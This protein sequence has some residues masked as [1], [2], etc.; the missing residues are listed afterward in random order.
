[1]EYIYYMEKKMEAMMEVL[2]QELEGAFEV[3]DKKSLHRYVLLLTE[4]IVKKE[5]YEKQQLELRNDIQT[6]AENQ[7]QGFEIMNQ[8]FEAIDKR[9]EA[10][11]KR[12]ETVDKRF[13][14]VDKRFEDMF[15]YMDKRFEDIDK[16]FQAVDRRF[17]D[18]FHYMDKRFETI[19][20]R[21]TRLFTFM[22]TGM[23]IIILI[24]ILFKFLR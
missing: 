7:K 2:E 21:F 10:I 4:N 13:E 14:T 19:E 12:F 8:R 23:G 1:M 6:L 24:T 15:H 20:K 11:D 5:N 3:K 22:N 16:R 17:E 18:M 9:F